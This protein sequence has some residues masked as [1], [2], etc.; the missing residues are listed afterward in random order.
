MEI[1][2]METDIALSLDTVVEKVNK[3][4]V[5]KSSVEWINEETLVLVVKAKTEEMENLSNFSLCGKKMIDWV[6]LATSIC[7]QKILESERE[8]FEN[9]LKF[10]HSYKQIAVFYSDT[11]LLQKATFLEIMNYFSARN[12]NFLPLPR[13]FVI[14]GEYAENYENL[15]SSPLNN[16]GTDDFFIVSD[17]K[18]LS[19]AFKKLNRRILQF[20]KSQ[21]VV[22]LGEENIYIEADVQ[23]ES[24]VIIY[25]FNTLK[26]ETYIGKNVMLESGNYI[27]DS[28]VLDGAFVVQSY[29][30]KSKVS[31]NKSVGPFEKF[32]NE[33]L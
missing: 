27:E 30:E 25:P 10:S 6:L 33:T 14:R 4:E 29:L 19:V 26:G 17:A 3:P 16:F 12:M 23:I 9:L 15:L 22:L 31:E 7:T 18:S 32:I 11:P 8:I 28:V 5:L 20:H 24:G 13:G 2:E 21:G 1:E